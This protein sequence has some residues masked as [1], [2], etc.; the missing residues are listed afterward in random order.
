MA[1]T[2]TKPL[3]TIGIDRYTFFKVTKDDDT[4]ISYAAPKSLKGMVQLTPSDS[5]GSD[6][7]DADNGAYVVDSYLEK[8]G[9]EIESADIP[10]EIDALWRGLDLVNG[11]VLVKGE[12]KQVYFGV[13]WR[14]LKSD[15]TYRYAKYFK[16]AYSFASNVG[17]KTKPSSGASDKQTAKATYTAVKTDYNGAILYYVDQADIQITSGTTS[18]S[19]TF[20]SLADFETAWFS[21]M[22]TMI[23]DTKITTATS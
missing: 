11:G 3:P 1:T 18:T 2:N 17:G 16:G 8:T 4:G 7:F 13:A 21:K 20:K 5:G 23:G 22:D 12:P 6:T 10:P 19:T 9:H 15:G 14:I